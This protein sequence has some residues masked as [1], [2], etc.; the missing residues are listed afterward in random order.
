MDVTQA[1][2]EQLQ[3][4][5]KTVLDKSINK[6]KIAWSIDWFFNLSWYLK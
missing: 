2:L 4:F 6:L 1:V 3:L 5:N